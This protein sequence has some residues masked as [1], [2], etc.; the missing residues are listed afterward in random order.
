MKWLKYFLITVLIPATAL[1]QQ[2]IRNDTAST[3]IGGA[4]LSQS[5]ISV[6]SKGQIY[7]NPGVSSASLGKQAKSA[8]G[9]TDTGVMAL[10]RRNTTLST[11]S[12]A[13]GTY[14]P[15][16]T[17]AQGQIY[18]ALDANA[19]TVTTT[20]PIRL[21]DDAFGG[22][23]GIMIAGGQGQDP[24]TSDQG[25]NGDVGPIKLDRTGRVITSPYAPHSEFWSSCGTATAVTTDVA[26]KAAVAS[27]R[28]YVTSITCKNTSSTTGSNLD[29]KD[30]TTINAVGSIGEFTIAA[31]NNGVNTYAI[32]FPV[33]LRGT[34]NTAF[35]FATNTAVTSVT[36]CGA[37]FI[38]VD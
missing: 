26:I 18:V 23:N 12:G 28:I 36:C 27:N 9:A 35:N 19:Q 11:I 5:A 24:L 3:D 6:D 30:G 32:T 33:P 25:T 14:S 17:G 10:G 4:N 31:A 7:I 16:A 2:I 34:S 20:S 21:E 15:L 13:D 1:S 22:A 38:S 37:G 8:Q 29:F